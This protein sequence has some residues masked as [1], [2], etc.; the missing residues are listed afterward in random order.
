MFKIGLGMAPRGEVGMVVA[1]LGLAS[2]VLT[3]RTYGAVVLMAV[4]TTV[5]T[6]LF[7]RFAFTA[8]ETGPDE[9]PEENTEW[10]RQAV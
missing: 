7:L 2:G 3:Q 10:E 4:L 6:P 5:A 8:D 9:S 1:Q